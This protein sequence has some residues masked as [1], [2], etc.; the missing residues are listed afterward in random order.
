MQ[1]ICKCLSFGAVALL[2]IYMAVASVLEKFCG[3]DAVMKWAYHSPVFVAFWALAALSGSVYLYFRII[4]GRNWKRIRFATA[5]IH[6]AFVMI[7]AG[8]FLTHI[9]SEHGTLHLRKGDVPAHEFM[10]DDGTVSAFPF[11]VELKDFRIEYYHGSSAP[12]DYVSTIGILTGNEDI[13]AAI[14]MNKIF[15]YQGYRFYQASY[16]DDGIGS[17]LAIS[18]DPA[19]VA[20]T[21][22][23]YALLLVCLAGFF[24]QRESGFRTALGQAF[25]KTAAIAAAF[26]LPVLSAGAFS[27]T[28]QK[29]D[30][31]EYH[32]KHLPKETAREYGRMY[33]YYNDRICQMQTLARDF[34]MKLYG[35]PS[36]RGLT[37]EQVLTGWIFYYGSWRDTAGQD[38]GG[39][40]A[41]MKAMDREEVIML[42]CS[43]RLLKIFPYEDREGKVTWY[44]SV[45]NLPYGMDEDQWLFVRKVMS[46][47][48]E[49]IMKKDF[50]A[51]GEI[52]S[53]IRD[54]QRKTAAD[55]LPSETCIVA[56]RIYNGIERIKAAAVCCLT[57]GLL[58]FILACFSLPSCNPGRRTWSGAAEAAARGA[59]FV[60]S[61]MAFVYLT[62][63]LILR[64]YISGH[65]PM[66][67]G[68]ETMV[69]LAWHTM[70]L[71]VFVRKKFPLIQPL[72]FLLTGFALLVA[73]F[74]SSDPQIARIMPVLSSPLL[75]VHV[76]CMMISYT[77]LG[78]AML[79]G[80]LELVRYSVSGKPALRGYALS[81]VILYP[82]VFF[83]A[84][85][86]FLGAVWANISWGRYWAWDPK[87]V[88]ALITLLVYAFA[89]HGGSLKAFR[90]PVFFHWFCIIAFL[91]VVITYFGVNFF[92]GGMH[93]YA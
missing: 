68:F 85:G 28:G 5:G 32:P 61:A 75:S 3:T 52:F 23:G 39:T 19:G 31:E 35:K 34:T 20:V 24:F 49:S 43:G 79:N 80:M 21:Y 59:A 71:T 42:L 13:E 48:G 65:V 27:G 90:S 89:L 70:M 8:A 1:R 63:I 72:G 74:G 38:A 22:T 84:A 36:Y 83:L 30:M 6:L 92:L 67:N 25:G 11:S 45:D 88:W 69:L 86:T 9:C 17:T 56:E 91:C 93:S 53:K 26:L 78:L 14:A 7:L 2:I 12:R 16:D 37:A 44:S 29:S 77:L 41:G 47:A 64:W 62:V 54:F 66:S 82:A 60:L 58:M 50:E 40:K 18:H 73:S 46:L 15:R 51:A 4:K 55:V 76:M 87:E 10:L 57:A 81:R 33:I